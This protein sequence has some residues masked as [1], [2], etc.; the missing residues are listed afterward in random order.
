MSSDKPPDDLDA[1]GIRKVSLKEQDDGGAS[2]VY[3]SLDLLRNV[4]PASAQRMLAVSFEWAREGAAQHGER[5]GSS[6][7][8]TLS[9]AYA[10][11]RDEMLA[12]AKENESG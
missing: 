10:F 12:A 7:L 6:D 1:T 5:A 9:S 11:A 8:E 3:H 2:A 4:L